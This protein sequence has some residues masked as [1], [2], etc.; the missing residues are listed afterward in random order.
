MG[1]YKDSKIQTLARKGNGNFAYV[2][3]YQEAEKIIMKEFTQT[4]YTVADDAHLHVTFDPSLVKQYRLIGFDNKVGALSDSTSEVEGGEIGSG[5]SIIATFEIEPNFSAGENVSSQRYAEIR[6]QYKLTM[7][8]A[9]REMNGTFAYDPVVYKELDPMYRFA[10]SVIMFGSI[11]KSS[12]FTK[13][14]SWGD[15]LYNSS[16]AANPTDANQSQFVELVYKA[17]SFYTK[18]KK[19]KG[20]ELR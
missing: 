11:L 7:D 5:Q 10:T 20:K 3:T 9:Q 19:K 6:L 2:D 13:D 14:I 1:N 17:K 8:T 15:V 18:Q 12:S 16:E 4:L